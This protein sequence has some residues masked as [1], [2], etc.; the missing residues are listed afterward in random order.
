[1]MVKRDNIAPVLYLETVMLM[2]E[3]ARRVDAAT[4]AG[5]VQWVGHVAKNNPFADCADLG[6]GSE[7]ALADAEYVSQRSFIEPEEF[8]EWCDVFDVAALCDGIDD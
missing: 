7:E 6:D 2:A 3:E 1:M 5:P 8:E 4:H